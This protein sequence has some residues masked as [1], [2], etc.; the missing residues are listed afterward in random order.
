MKKMVWVVLL[1]ALWCVSASAEEKSVTYQRTF[2]AADTTAAGLTRDTVYTDAFNVGD[3]WRYWFTVLI[4]SWGS[5]KDTNFANDTVY[6]KL[7][8]SMTQDGQFGWVTRTDTIAKIGLT[9]ADFDTVLQSGRFLDWDTTS[10]PTPL[11]KWVR[12]MVIYRDSTEANVPGLISN[13]Y[14]KRFTVWA[15]GVKR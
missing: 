4:D 12:F 9:S 13:S 6:F 2:D 8:H 5:K 10:A 1:L 7:Q 11:H 3:M 14:Y 15:E